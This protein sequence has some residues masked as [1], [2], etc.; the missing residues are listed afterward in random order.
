MSRQESSRAVSGDFLGGIR[1]GIAGAVPE[2]EHWGNVRDLDRVIL[3]FV[4]QLSALVMKYGGKVVHGS[5][6]AFTPVLV[7]QARKY[8]KK[9]ALTLIASK[10]WGDPPEVTVHPV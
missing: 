3:N 2:P 8:P 6:P 1:V 4:A 9:Q 5:Q 7:E 10:L